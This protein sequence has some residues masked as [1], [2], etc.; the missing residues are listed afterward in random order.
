MKWH[1]DDFI[2]SSIDGA[3][4]TFA[5]IAGVVGVELSPGIILILG[6]ANLFA[7][8]FSMAAAMMAYLIGY[9]LSFL[10]Q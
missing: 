8:G 6:F 4:T 10:V 3:V 7:D 5:I 9:G 1:F 2:Y